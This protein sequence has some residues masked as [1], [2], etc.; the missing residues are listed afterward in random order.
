L[1]MGLPVGGSAPT[2]HGSLLATRSAVSRPPSSCD[3]TPTTMAG[4]CDGSGSTITAR[5]DR[6]GLSPAMLARS[7]RFVRPSSTTLPFGSKRRLLCGR[8]MS[9]LST[10]SALR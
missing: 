10:F 5:H 7:P 3:D 9:R 1:S 6:C 4:R 8:S 2:T